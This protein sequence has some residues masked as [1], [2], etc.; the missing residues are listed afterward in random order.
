MW[1]AAVAP[2]RAGMVVIR[3]LSSTARRV[4]HDCRA[5]NVPD[6]NGAYAVCL[7]SK[8]MDD[9]ENKVSELKGE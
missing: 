6:C 5:V 4:R 8:K 3:R 7:L 2:Y 9:A 1:A